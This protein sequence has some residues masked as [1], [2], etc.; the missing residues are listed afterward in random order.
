MK[1]ENLLPLVNRLQACPAQST[2]FSEK[3]LR[4]TWK[5]FRQIN[6]EHGEELT[7]PMVAALI[8]Y[9]GEQ[10]AE[11]L[12][13]KETSQLFVLAKTAFDRYQ[14]ITNP[15]NKLGKLIAGILKKETE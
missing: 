8:L 10:F 1:S 4:E 13:E 14:Q 11:L 15:P 2:D 12:N 3:S 7:P 6:L 9:D 5:F